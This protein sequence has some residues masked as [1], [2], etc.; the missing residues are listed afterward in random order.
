MTLQDKRTRSQH[1][2][3][4]AIA[5]H[6]VLGARE[7]PFGANDAPLL[8]VNICNSHQPR[9]WFKMQNGRSGLFAADFYVVGYLEDRD[10]IGGPSTDLGVV[11]GR[12][13]P[14]W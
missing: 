3:G 9:T 12:T 14:S 2:H 5:A 11:A 6:R 8:P 1:P 4:C 13:E 10:R 7:N